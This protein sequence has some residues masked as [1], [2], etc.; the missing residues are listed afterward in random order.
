MLRFGSFDRRST[1]LGE[2]SAMV[3]VRTGVEEAPGAKAV[4]GRWR[5]LSTQRLAGRCGGGRRLPCELSVGGWTCVTER[6]G[7]VREVV[8]GGPGLAACLLELPAARSAAADSSFVV[9]GRG[10][11][12]RPSDA[13]AGA[14]SIDREL[15]SFGS[16]CEVSDRRGVGGR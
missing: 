10:V 14:M 3:L 15:V 13:S 2:T 12:A 8:A 6:S 11:A 9:A 4:D 1:L 5:A 16:C 7:A